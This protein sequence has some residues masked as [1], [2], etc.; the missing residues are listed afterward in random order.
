MSIAARRVRRWNSIATNSSVDI[1]TGKQF[2]ASVPT[3]SGYPI[4]N[5]TDGNLSTRWISTPQDNITATVDMAGVYSLDQITLTWAGNTTRNYALSI[6]L[7][8]TNWTTIYTGT[9]SGSASETAVIDSF[10][11]LAVGRYLRITCIDRQPAATSGNWGHSIWEVA[12][13]GVRNDSYHIGLI[14]DLRATANISVPHVELNWTY[15]GDPLSNYIIKRDGATIATL[16]DINAT[17]Y[18]DTTVALENTYQYS[19]TGTLVGGSST[20]TATVSINITAATRDPI[21]QPYANTSPWNLPIVAGAATTDYPS[22]RGASGKFTINRSSWSHGVVIAG[23]NDPYVTCID[24]SYS[25][26]YDDPAHPLGSVQWRV[27]V[28]AHPSDGAD[29]HLEVVNVQDDGRVE[30]LEMFSAD[31]H[32][33]GTITCTRMYITDLKG[34]GIGPANGVRAYGGCAIAGLIREWEV[35]TT[36]PRYTGSINHVLA[37]AIDRYTMLYKNTSAWNG[38]NWGYYTGGST[39][40][41]QQPGWNP[42]QPRYGF[43]CQTGY[44]WPATEQDGF[45]MA[46]NEYN[47]DIPMGAYFCI[48]DSV[49]LSSLN[50][51]SNAGLMTARAMQDYGVYVSDAASSCAALYVEYVNSSTRTSNYVSEMGHGWESDSDLYKVMS[52]LRRVDLNNQNNPNGGPLDAPRRAPLLPDFD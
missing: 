35:D 27:P 20:N 11:N 37:M 2:T 52:A 43:G 7:D 41:T 50:L 9:N 19:V 5:M 31:R 49:P 39:N 40:S 48:P 13:T 1:L 22:L 28:D 23:P 47:G 45:S 8:G 6:S 38:V 24:T 30:M 33:N 32:S 10:S 3:A 44:V 4:G 16:T 29:A 42:G 34:S 46:S 26:S 12:A 21:Y 25:S 36:N 15:T 14:T 18:T 17:S 51:S